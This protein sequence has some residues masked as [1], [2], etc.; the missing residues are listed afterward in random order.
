MPQGRDPRPLHLL[1]LRE[2]LPAADPQV[3]GAAHRQQMLEGEATRHILM[4]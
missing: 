4:S 1:R 2:Q 3:L